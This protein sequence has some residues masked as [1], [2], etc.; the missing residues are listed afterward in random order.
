MLRVGLTGGVGSGKSAAAAMLSEL[1]AFVSSSDAIGRRLMER[2]QDVYQRIAEHFGRG[3]LMD[4]GTLDRA[5]LARIAFE[6]GR[7]EELNA[8]V[9]P[10]VLAEQQ[11]WMTSVGEQDVNAVAVV[12]SALI[13]ETRWSD[14]TSDA[15]WRTRFDRIVVITAP[16]DVRKAR[17]IRRLGGSRTEDAGSD[18]ERRAAA[19]WSDDRKA[20]LADDVVRNEGTLEELRSAVERLFERLRQE[21]IDR[22]AEAM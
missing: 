1:G 16:V 7:A 18:F 9:H 5:A 11:R 6:D 20:G 15:P 17:Y 8:I 2:G 13:F 14:G 21:A 19:Q 4:D 12:E 22:A 10:A 3:V